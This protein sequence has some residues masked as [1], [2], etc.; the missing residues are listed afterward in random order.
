MKKIIA[1]LLP[2][3]ICFGIKLSAQTIIDYQAWNPSSPP[4]N[5]FGSATN[6]PATING[7]SGTVAHLTAIGQPQYDG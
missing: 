3:T 5:L 1:V 4:C 6:V 7:S 2:I